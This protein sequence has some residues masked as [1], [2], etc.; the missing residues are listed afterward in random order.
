MDMP[1]SLENTATRSTRLSLLSEAH[2][3]P[4]TAFVAVIRREMGSEYQLPEFDPMDGGTQAEC[5]FLLEAPGP[6]A[7]V[8]GFVSRNNPDETAKNFFELNQAVGLTRNR[9]VSWNVVPW[10]VGNG[11]QIRPVDAKDLTRSLPYISKLL[12]LLPRLRLVV[13]VGKK[14]AR[15]EPLIAQ[16]NPSLQ[17]LKTPHPSPSFVNRSPEIVRLFKI[18]LGKLWRF[19][20]EKWLTR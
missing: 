13:L 12:N 6:K 9:T 16:L 14:A 15:T 19:S 7:I 11:T 18:A 2:I 17:I 20:T 10:Y 3:A 5:L 8:T 4:L 1:K